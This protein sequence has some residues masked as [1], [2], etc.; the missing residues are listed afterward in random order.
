MAMTLDNMS[1]RYATDDM[2]KAGEKPA[3]LVPI[4]QSDQAA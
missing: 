4:D 2:K 1:A 3:S